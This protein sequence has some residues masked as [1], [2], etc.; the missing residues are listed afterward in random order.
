M[1]HIR[2][3]RATLAWVPERDRGIALP[4]LKRLRK[5]KLLNQGALA[6]AAGVGRNTVN[7]AERGATIDMESARKLAT[8]FEVDATE[9]MR[10]E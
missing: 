3:S 4:G 10:A 1:H 2:P 8:F 6:T 9:L 5:A 7:R